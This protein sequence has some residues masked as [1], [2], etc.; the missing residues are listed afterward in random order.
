MKWKG[1]SEDGKTITLH[2]FTGN[3]NFPHEPSNSRELGPSDS[4][5]L[6]M[7]SNEL[8]PVE[9]SSSESEFALGATTDVETTGLD[10]KIENVIEIGIRVFK[11]H[12]KT[13]KI[14]AW[15]DSYSELQDPGRPLSP[16]IRELT[17]LT[18][19]DLKGRA[20]DWKHVGALF[21]RC[22]IIIA[23]NAAFD[24]PFIEKELGAPTQKL[25]ACS[26][27]Q[28]DWAAKGYG[29]RSLEILCA[30]HGF[31][32][33]AHRALVDADVLLH[34]LSF[35][36]EATSQS[37]FA[38]LLNTSSRQQ[39]RLI[40]SGA[41]FE[42]KTILRDRG[43]RWDTLIRAWTKYMPLDHSTEEVNWLEK[44]VYQGPFRGQIKEIPLHQQFQ[45]L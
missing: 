23:H 40:A 18:D 36:D 15:V 12:K 29:V 32:A 22:D 25:W 3:F 31:F 26:L 43:Y 4:F 34:L 33:D 39:A 41:P 38:E 24:R 1:L 21:D 45:A 2:R 30:F 20:I 44:E 5:Q 9:T 42:S 11:F 7:F 17:G 19:E 13:G 8:P 6:Q 28:V 37:Y 27:K 16:V 14:V 35:E 10:V